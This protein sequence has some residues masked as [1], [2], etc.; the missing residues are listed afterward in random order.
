MVFDSFGRFTQRTIIGS[1]KKVVEECC[2]VY[3]ISLCQKG[4]T[5]SKVI[6]CYLFRSC[7]ILIYF[8]GS[9]ITL[10]LKVDD[11]VS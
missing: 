7:V 5:I 1:F 3:L 2:V 8:Y 6:L 11:C 9:V 10:L 4:I